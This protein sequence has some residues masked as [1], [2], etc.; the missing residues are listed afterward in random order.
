M[1][2]LEEKGCVIHAKTNLDEFGMGS[3]TQH[4]IHGITRN[5]FDVDRVSGGSSGGSA[6]AVASGMCH[7]YVYVVEMPVLTM[8]ND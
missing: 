7:T 5:P 4:S 8:A 3:Y 1:T 6:A 2:L